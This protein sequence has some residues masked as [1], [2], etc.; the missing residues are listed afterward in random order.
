MCVWSLGREDPLEEVM[1]NHSSIFAW[2]IS[3]KEE[4]VRLRSTG[5]QRAGYN[6][7]DL[8]CRH[9][10]SLPLFFPSS[11]LGGAVPLGQVLANKSRRKGSIRLALWSASSFSRS[12]LWSHIFYPSPSERYNE[13]AS[14]PSGT[15]PFLCHHCSYHHSTQGNRRLTLCPARWPRAAFLSVIHQ[16]APQPAEQQLQTPPHTPPQV[17]WQWTSRGWALKSSVL[18]SF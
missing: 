6:W 15:F 7:S 1:A 18:R 5:L 4:P 14:S 3:C 13:G 9:V 8:A 10:P 17:S 12:C 11:L 16:P 2:R